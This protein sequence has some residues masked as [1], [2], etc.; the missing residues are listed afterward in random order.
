MTLNDKQIVLLQ[1]RLA[2]IV[3]FAKSVRGMKHEGLIEGTAIGDADK[4]IMGIQ[5]AAEA[6]HG[7]FALRE[8][9]EASAD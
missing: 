9:P 8:V 4:A 7:W 3:A 5:G 2:T 6:M 1:D